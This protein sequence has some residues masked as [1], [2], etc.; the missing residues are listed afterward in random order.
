MSVTKDKSSFVFTGWH[1]VG[2]MAAFFGTVISVNLLM[3]YYAT[4]TWSGLVVENTYVAS[5]EFNGKTAAIRDMLASG[6]KGRLAVEDGEIRYGLEIP[7]E[8]PVVADSVTAHF[9]RPVGE[10]QDFVA[11]LASVGNGEYVARRDILP[12]DWI[13]EIRAEKDGRMIMHEASRIS[14]AGGGK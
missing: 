10:H 14:V 12:G 4:T 11:A 1:M 13:V 5:Q 9:K 8:G 6:I 2:V 7:G 3:A